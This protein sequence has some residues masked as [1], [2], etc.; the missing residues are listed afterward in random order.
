[1]ESACEAENA[2]E[3]EHGALYWLA[4]HSYAGLKH[5]YQ[6]HRLKLI[7]TFIVLVFVCFFARAFVQP[8]VLLM[9]IY[10]VEVVLTIAVLWLLTKFSRHMGKKSW[11]AVVVILGVIIST[12]FL[13]WT[14]HSYMTLYLQ[15]KSLSQTALA[16]IPETDYERVQPLSSIRVFANQITTNN[17]SPTEPYNVWVDGD[18]RWTMGVEP[19]YFWGRLFGTITEV[20]CVSAT[21]SSPDFSKENRHAV[22]FQVGEN[23]Y[24]GK[25]AHVC[26]VKTFGIGRFLSYEP[27]DVRYLKDDGGNWV[28][29]ISLVKWEGFFFPQP[30]FGGVHVIPQ[31][32]GG[33]L[34]FLK[35]LCVGDGEFIPPEAISQHSYLCGQNLVPFQVSRHVAQSFRFHKGFIA[36]LWGYHQHDLCIP[37]LPGDYN[38]Q[39]FTTYFRTGDSGKLY[40]YFA[41]EP[42]QLDKR[43][44]SLS[45]LVPADGIGNVLV[46]DHD[47]RRES[48]I[49]VSAVEGQIKS[50][51]K[52]YDW[53]ENSPAENRPYVRVIDGKRRFLWLTTIV[54]KGN[55]KAQETGEY[56]A[57]S[58]PEVTLTDPIGLMPVW[59]DSR[60]P[61]TWDETLSKELHEFWNK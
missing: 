21:D 9:R 27:A 41:L 16:E 30:T 38:D 50:S 15:H 3:R 53:T 23:M 54:T 34:H 45:V 46:Y 35:T 18:S 10:S 37:D 26:A 22:N 8:Y 52:F 2:P 36:P 42:Y 17:V 44:L 7:V 55:T 24:L 51:K 12:S 57:G 20:L 13:S 19:S 25:N 60:Y 61:E 43:G 29:V 14:P 47:A 1:M 11:A 39:P 40:Q 58:V 32:E 56:V 49:G 4:V 5:R 59:V 48:M 6:T 33:L 28:Q 31:S